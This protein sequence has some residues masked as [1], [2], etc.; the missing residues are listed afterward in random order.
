MFPRHQN[1]N[2][3]PWQF[4]MVQGTSPRLAGFDA[5]GCPRRLM[6]PFQSSSDC[7]N[8][9]PVSDPTTSLSC[10]YPRLTKQA[11]TCGPVTQG[12]LREAH[13]SENRDSSACQK[14]CQGSQ[15][16]RG[17]LDASR[18]QVVLCGCWA[19]PSRRQVKPSL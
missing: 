15:D 17:K 11:C 8:A 9:H 13:A 19:S 4:M 12:T 16:A 3:N 10:L 5:N 1:A 7:R 18:C 14:S 2:L 6:L